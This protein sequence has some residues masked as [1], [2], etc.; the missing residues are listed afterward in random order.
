MMETVFLFCTDAGTG[1]D[2]KLSIH[3]IFN[4]LHAPDFPARQDKMILV[5]IVEWQRDLRGR[6]PFTVDLTDP[7]GL[8][9]FSIEGHTDV[10]SRPPSKAPAKTQLILPL[11]DVM[12]PAPGHYRVRININGSELTGPSM[13]LIRS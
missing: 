2:G 4:E 8:A 13:H 5:G 12:F 7:E 3:G 11:K 10:E 1:P 9:I 6:I